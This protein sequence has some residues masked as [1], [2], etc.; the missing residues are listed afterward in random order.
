MLHH[1]HH[2][3]AVRRVV[4]LVLDAVR[5][6]ARQSQVGGEMVTFE[7]GDV[8]DV[9]V[10]RTHCEVRLQ[11]KGSLQAL[12]VKVSRDMKKEIMLSNL[13]VLDVQTVVPRMWEITPNFAQA[14]NF[15]LV[16]ARILCIIGETLSRQ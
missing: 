11:P 8:V 12:E 4:R 7:D 10:V 3:A 1:Q 15:T 6:L 16:V 13:V 2:A 14:S 9:F 5:V